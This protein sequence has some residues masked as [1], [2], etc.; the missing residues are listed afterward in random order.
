MQ[1]KGRSYEDNSFKLSP[2]LM[3]AGL[4]SFSTSSR[5]VFIVEMRQLTQTKNNMLSIP[6]SAKGPMTKEKNR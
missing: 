3:Y 4:E 6:D 2:I 1:I 5:I